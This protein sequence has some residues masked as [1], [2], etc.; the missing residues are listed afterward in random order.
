MRLTRSRRLRVGV[1]IAMSRDR[2]IRQAQFWRFT[3]LP[4]L[5]VQPRDAHSRQ[6]SLL[7]RLNCPDLRSLG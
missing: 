4:T 2:P 1:T 5:M 6:A 7:Q 3:V